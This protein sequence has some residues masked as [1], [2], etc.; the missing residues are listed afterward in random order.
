MQQAKLIRGQDAKPRPADYFVCT[1]WPH[2]LTSAVLTAFPVIAEDEIFLRT[3]RQLFTGNAGVV[4]TA[5]S[6]L[7]IYR[8]IVDIDLS[9]A[10]LNL[11][12]RKADDPFYV[13][14]ICA[15]FKNDDVKTLG[16]SEQIA[17]LFDDQM[18]FIL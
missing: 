15:V 14:G 6:V 5:V 1:D 9:L 7:I 17:D 8:L 4:H 16:F 13:I 2:R 11:F 3:E 18:V 12:S 10:D